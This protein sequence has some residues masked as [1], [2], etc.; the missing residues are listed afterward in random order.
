MRKWPCKWMHASREAGSL[1]IGKLHAGE[2]EHR[3]CR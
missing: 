1:R 3:C 2:G